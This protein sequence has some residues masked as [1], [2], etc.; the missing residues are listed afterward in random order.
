LP[1]STQRRR[2]RRRRRRTNT[3]RTNDL[4]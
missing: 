1:V 4:I 2:R 3:H